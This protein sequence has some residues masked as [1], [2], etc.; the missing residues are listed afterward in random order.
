MCALAACM[1]KMIQ[2]GARVG[3]E[4]QRRR[5]GCAHALAGRTCSAP[6]YAAD[7]TSASRRCS[8]VASCANTP[9]WEGAG[10]RRRHGQVLTLRA[11]PRG[12]HCRNGPAACL[13]CVRRFA[14][15]AWTA[16]APCRPLCQSR[17]HH[18]RVLADQAALDRLRHA[19]V[20]HAKAG[21][22]RGP[23]GGEGVGGGAGVHNGMPSARL[24]G[25]QR[26]C[27]QR[28]SA[29]WGGQ[30]C[31]P[32]AAPLALAGGRLS[33]RL[34]R[35]RRFLRARRHLAEA[36][37][38]CAALRCV[39]GAAG[40][41]GLACWWPTSMLQAGAAS[42]Q[43]ATAQARA[44]PSAG[45]CRFRAPPSRAPHLPAARPSPP[46][47]C[48][49]PAWPRP[50]VARA[51]RRGGPRRP[52][53]PLAASAVAG[54]SSE[55][56]P[57][58]RHI[59]HASACSPPGA[60]ATKQS[61]PPPLADAKQAQPPA[62]RAHPERLRLR[63]VVGEQ[64]GQLPRSD[65]AAAARALGAGRSGQA[66]LQDQLA[67]QAAAATRWLWRGQQRCVCVCVWAG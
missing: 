9:T 37:L 31:A 40:G 32:A 1:G 64:H 44:W 52:R 63:R 50:P 14:P 20:G 51:P 2:T 19:A 3:A 24:R 6:P 41:W 8:T 47:G 53:A 36:E 21:R 54:A 60:R 33:P 28:M 27:L 59:A 55:G 65:P 4:Q 56:M 25:P 43:T 61:H 16:L 29:S 35:G 12:A 15:G 22:N 62:V 57:Q 10:Q 5:C 34:Q 17:A 26:R 66:R 58:S 46:C 7:S 49:L 11:L 30:A 45:C 18:V 48:R 39:M 13:C 67:F 23:G 38:L 42:R